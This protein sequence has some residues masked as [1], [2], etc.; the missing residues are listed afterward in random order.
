VLA[1]AYTDEGIA[2]ALQQQ[3]DQEAAAAAAAAGGDGGRVKQGRAKKAPE[4][5]A[6]KIR[7]HLLG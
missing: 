2:A 4:R 5:K 3:L 1:G 7:K 6:D